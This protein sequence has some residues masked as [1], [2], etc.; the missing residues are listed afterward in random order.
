MDIGSQNLSAK[1][2]NKESDFGLFFSREKWCK[3]DS[4]L[5]FKEKLMAISGKSLGVQGYL[6]R[7][8]SKI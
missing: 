6:Y 7:L 8:R 4:I 2:I 1:L 3:T 5:Y